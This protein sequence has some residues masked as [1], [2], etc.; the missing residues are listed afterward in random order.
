MEGKRERMKREVGRRD[1][2]DSEEG[3]ECYA[4]E[5][6]FDLML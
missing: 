4:R 5:A 6:I 1:T 2:E 3:Q